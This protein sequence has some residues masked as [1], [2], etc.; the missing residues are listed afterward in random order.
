M[1][2]AAHALHGAGFRVRLVHAAAGTTSP[3]AGQLLP[4]GSLI[5]LGDG[6]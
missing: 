1:R 6:L 5:S 3:V 4:A 2:Q